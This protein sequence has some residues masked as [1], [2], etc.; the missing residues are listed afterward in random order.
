[1]VAHSLRAGRPAVLAVFGLVLLLVPAVPASHPPAAIASAESVAAGPA[2]VVHLQATVS[3]NGHN[4]SE[5]RGVHSAF[6]VTYSSSSLLAFHWSA[7]ASSVPVPVSTARV[8]LYFFGYGVG[9]RDVS[10]APSPT[11]TNGTINLS[12]DGANALRWL[13]EG[14]YAAT[15]SL[16]DGTGSTLW[17]EN[18]YLR[19]TAPYSLLALIPI[20]LLLLGIFEVAALLRSGYEPPSK[21]PPT[22]RNAEKA[23]PPETGAAPPVEEE[24]PKT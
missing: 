19:V 23:E 4:I 1:M 18:F 5:A 15:A 11:A 12:W 16:L 8:E 9:A 2:S 7:P 24:G 20:V 14:T 21:P 22:T 3:W 6:P 17:S 13:A 10:Q